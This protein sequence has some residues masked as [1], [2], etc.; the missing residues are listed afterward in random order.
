MALKVERRME[1]SRAANV[2]VPVFSV[3]AALV[4][5]GLLLALVGVNP[6]ETYRAMIEGAF[7]SA[8]SISEVLVPRRR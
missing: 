2:L 6:L 7:G 4:A 1:P 8:Y 5:G 3:V